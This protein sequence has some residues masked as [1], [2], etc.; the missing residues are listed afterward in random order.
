M[1]NLTLT[2]QIGNSFLT[3]EAIFM[4]SWGI[5]AVASNFGTNEYDTD[6]TDERVRVLVGC[7]VPHE[8]AL[9]IDEIWSTTMNSGGTKEE[10]ITEMNKM[11]NS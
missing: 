3:P 4:L 6:T 11:L 5:E 10:F 9:A 1:A 7:G 8:G 2:T